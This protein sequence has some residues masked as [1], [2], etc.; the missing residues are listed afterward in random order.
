MS[1]TKNIM[2]ERGIYIERRDKSKRIE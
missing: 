1:P 2:L